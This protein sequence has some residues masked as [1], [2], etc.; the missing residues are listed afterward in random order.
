MIKKIIII[1]VA[2]ILAGQVSAQQKGDFTSQINQ[3]S[4]S[5]FSLL[6]P[7]RFHM[8]HSFSLS[9]NSS[10]YG[11][12]SMGMY[13]NSIEYQVSDPLKIRLDLGYAQN[14]SALFGSDRGNLG[15]GRIIPALS[16]SWNPSRNLYF[17]FNYREVPAFY[18]DNIC[19]DYNTESLFYENGRGY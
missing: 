3:P 1:G 10:K 8:S 5:S 16:I 15:N 6:D 13:F 14:T 12:Q 17:H 9:Y 19:N 18:Y 11:S 4:Q 7:S 2:V